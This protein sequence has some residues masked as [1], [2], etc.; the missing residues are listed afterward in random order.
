MILV[1][2]R[3][4]ILRVV[5]DLLDALRDLL[6]VHQVRIGITDDRLERHVVTGNDEVLQIDGAAETL[7]VIHHIDGGD[8]VIITGLLDE[9]VHRLADREIPA[10][11]DVVC[12]DETSDLIVVVGIDEADLGL[13]LV[14]DHRTKLDAHALVDV[15][16]EI[17]RIIRVHLVDDL[18]E[19][20]DADL[21]DVLGR[22]IQ[23]GDHLRE[24]LCIERR[25]EQIPLRA[26]QELK[27]LRDI[28]LM[29]AAELLAHLIQGVR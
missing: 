26:V 1:Q 20:H 13:R 25:I 3:E 22:I 15:L 9:L 21:L 5:L 8:I 14:I 29:V 2:Y 16:P 19:L 6:V 23:I 10:D 11:A 28:V 27:A 24:P 7:A 18:R 4:G 17:D 12:R